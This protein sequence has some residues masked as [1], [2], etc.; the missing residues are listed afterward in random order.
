[1]NERTRAIAITS[2][3]IR[4]VSQTMPI[5]TASFL[6]RSGQLQSTC[7][8]W[9]STFRPGRTPMTSAQARMHP[10]TTESNN[11]STIRVDPSVG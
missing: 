7:G 1:L 8:R 9:G 4:T 10:A 3:R 11:V 5:T 6:W 2:S